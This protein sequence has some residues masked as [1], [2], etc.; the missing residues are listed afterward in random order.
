MP[1]SRPRVPLPSSQ[2]AVPNEDD[3]DNQSTVDATCRHSRPAGP[4]HRAR[5]ATSCSREA[6]MAS[7]AQAPD[8]TVG[9]WPELS[10]VVAS[11]PARNSADKLLSPPGGWPKPFTD[12]ATLKALLGKKGLSGKRCRLTGMP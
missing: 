7:A 10:D 5:L 9:Y 4:R 8:G 3:L 6:T 2:T 1:S 11:D 12:N